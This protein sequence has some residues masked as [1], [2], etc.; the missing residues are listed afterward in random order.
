MPDLKP[1]IKSALANFDQKPLREA[2]HSLF[3]ELGYHSDRTLDFGSVPEFLDQY[4]KKGLLKDFQPVKLWKGISLVFQLTGEDIKKGSSKQLNLLAPD[5]ADLSKRQIQSY[6]FVAIE[7]SPPDEGKPRTRTELCEIAR[8]INRL[9]PMPVLVVFKESEFLSIAITYRRTNKKDASKDV[10]SR[11]VTL[12][13]D[14]RYASPHTGHLA[15]LEDFALPTLS[16]FRGRDI[17]T[18]ADLDAAWN[19]SLS[20]E[21]LRRRA[22]EMLAD[23]YFWARQHAEFPPDALP[24]ADGKPSIHIIRLLTRVIFCWFVKEKSLPNGQPLIPYD[25]FDTPRIRE[26]L[27]DSSPEATTYYTA[28]LQ[29]LFFA[30][31]NTEMD[32]D[33]E[34]VARRFARK[35]KS[36]HMVHTLWRHE[37]QLREPDQFAKL[38]RDVPFLNGGLFECLDDRVEIEGS[39]FTKEIRVDGFSTDPAKHPRLPNFLFF[40]SDQTA[41]LSEATG[42]R[43]SSVDV[44]PL[45]S[46]LN[47]FVWT[48]TEST[49]LEEEV[50]LDPDLLGNVFEN[51]LAS[52]NP[53][54]GTVARNATGSFY[55]PDYV[56]DWMVEK[57]LLPLLVKALPPKT[58]NAEARVNRL[59]D[60]NEPGHDFDEKETANLIDCISKL[61][62]LDPACGSGA[63]PM[64]LLKKMVRVLTKLDPENIL[65]KRKQIEIAEQIDSIPARDEALAAIERAFARNHDD[66]GRKLYLIENGIYGVDIQPLAVQIAKLRFF[67]TLIVDQPIEPNGPGVTNYGILPLPNLETKIVPANTLLGLQRGQLMLG[68][69]EVRQLE[70]ELKSVRHRYFTARRYQDKK[71]LRKR[72]R[73]ICKQLAKALVDSG[74]CSPADAGRLVEWN[75]YNT[76]TFA[77]FFDPGWMFGLEGEGGKFDLV[78]GNPPYVR[79]EELKSV[80]VKDSA[81]QQRPLK[82]VLKSQYECFTGTADL[83]VYFFE[84]SIE[85]LRVGGVLS[86]ITS[87]KYFRAGYGE[88]L[89]AYLLYATAPQVILDFGDTNIFTAVAYPCIIVTEKVRDVQELPDPKTFQHQSSFEN[90]VPHADRE[91]AVLAW[92]PGPS[93]IE[94]PEIFE[95]DRVSLNQKDLKPSGWRL[96][97]PVG[98]RMSERLRQGNTLLGDYCEGRLYRGVL[99]GY[100]EAFVVEKEIANQLIKDHQSSELI[101]KPFLRGRD[102][103]KW[104]C[105]YAEQYLIQLESSENVTHPWSGLP[106]AKAEAVFAKTYPAIYARF[107]EPERRAKLIN[108]YDQGKYF[109][110][111]RSCAYW[112]EFSAPK[113]FIPAIQDRVQYAP[114]DTAFIGNDKTN[115]VIPPSIPF[116]LAILNSQISMWLTQQEFASKQG[117]YFEFKPMYVS[118]L[119]IPNTSTLQQQSCEAL[120]HALIHLHLFEGTPIRNGSLM[121]TFFEQWLNGLVYELFFP[122][123]LHARNI[124]LFD[125]TE[126]VNFPTEPQSPTYGEDLQAAFTFAHDLKQPLRGMLADLQTIEE[127]MII[128]GTK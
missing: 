35:A 81:G 117:G 88:K 103:K 27:K 124:R 22:Y 53:E 112:N 34:P 47:R 98:L 6:I 38:V 31:L 101:L 46:I 14:I 97:S 113:I 76:N 23:W 86:F 105:E 82:E 102:V 42:S 92:Q 79:Q 122:G 55:T 109:W 63:Y 70:R 41:D 99:T 94:F 26:I 21:L 33:G 13:K 106:E 40:G 104:R 7:L 57:A 87:N 61:R 3:G 18:F 58:K 78:V 59:L 48:I 49:P 45:L 110:E 32:K 8:A 116:T 80:M 119:P 125:F 19:E 100:N 123:E 5:P 121:T 56:V 120:S 111:L 24:D 62:T 43:R 1:F 65:W 16:K 96:E 2:A 127:V 84:K 91:I 44:V 30:T 72:D 74:E 107:N 29:N 118:K 114:D 28:V 15:I 71:S 39:N 95:Q 17:K 90:Y 64:G 4:D 52:Y 12:I 69:N 50:A 67:I 75:P 37:E 128:E 9:F 60:W 89:R 115:I 54:T 68:S 20:V 77:G 10:V 66:Y 51:L 83:Y 36:D 108:R 93:K 126:T 11:K 85:L 73:E 25:L